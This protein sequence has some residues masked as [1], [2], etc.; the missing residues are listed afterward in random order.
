MNDS[1][2]SQN[3]L[4]LK[5]K[6]S[7]PELPDYPTSLDQVEWMFKQLDLR[8]GNPSN[9]KL[10][11]NGQQTIRF[12]LKYLSYHKQSTCEEIAKKEFDDKIQTKIKLKSITDDVRKFMQ[13][14]LLWAQLIHE[15]GFKKVRNHHIQTYSLTPVGILY[16]LYLF[17]NLRLDVREIRIGQEYQKID[18]KFIRSLAKEYSHVLPKVFGRFEIFE[19]VIGDEFE[20][21][22]TSPLGRMFS[23][24][25]PW[26]VA[27]PDVMLTEYAMYD[28]WSSELTKN[29]PHD[30]IAEQI[31]LV[32]YANLQS[33]IEDMVRHR[34]FDEWA[35]KQFKNNNPEQENKEQTQ[36]RYKEIEK[37]TKEKWMVIMDG[38]KKLKKEYQDF[39]KMVVGSKRK[40][41]DTLKWYQKQVYALYVKFQKH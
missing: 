29:G 12:I 14:N 24:P 26:T 41:L 39:V 37:I 25:D 32:F 36:E 3:T 20:T 2:I 28:F 16:A 17:A 21:I 40:E 22:A 33:S 19:K 30:L 27:D 23:Q 34:S 5:P 35:R 4:F 38:D 8:Y 15:D 31:S 1:K 7:I 11:K 18:S 6:K 13:N 10:K 9:D